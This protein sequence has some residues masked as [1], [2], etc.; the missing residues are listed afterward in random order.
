MPEITLLTN[1]IR[2]QLKQFRAF[3]VAS[4]VKDVRVWWRKHEHLFPDIAPVPRALLGIPGSQ[5]ECERIFNIAGLIVGI[6]RTRLSPEA[7]DEIVNIYKNYPDDPTYNLSL[8]KGAEDELNPAA[9][10][11][12]LVANELN[13]HD[14]YESEL[15]EA[16]LLE[17]SAVVIDE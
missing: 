11:E 2:A 8:L 16:G 12:T 6:R 4:D 7:L 3:A 13:T 1:A 5:I 9:E 15:R 17:E 14:R 10:W